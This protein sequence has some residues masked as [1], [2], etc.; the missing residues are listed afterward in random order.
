MEQDRKGRAPGP[1][2]EWDLAAAG[3]VKAA[4]E[5]AAE[6]RVVVAARDK[7]MAQAKAKDAA[8]PKRRTTDRV[9][10][11]LQGEERGHARRS[12]SRMPSKWSR[13]VSNGSRGNYHRRIGGMWPVDGQ[14]DAAARVEA[15]RRS[16]RRQFSS[17][18][19]G[20]FC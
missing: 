13:N 12:T 5:D 9:S 1:V 15:A 17:I 2:V 16:T 19:T 4:V 3:N 7:A 18:S 14:N 8:K 20:P 6:G 10:E 11:L